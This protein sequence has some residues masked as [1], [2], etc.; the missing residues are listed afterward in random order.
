MAL[1]CFLGLVYLFA[2]R[3]SYMNT[4]FSLFS[5]PSLLPY[6]PPLKFKG[7]FK[8][9]CYTLYVCTHNCLNATYRVWVVLTFRPDFIGQP[10]KGLIP[11]RLIVFA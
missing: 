10:I 8:K 3:M 9:Y 7:Y 2:F 11:R 4:V 1:F 6:I 5:T